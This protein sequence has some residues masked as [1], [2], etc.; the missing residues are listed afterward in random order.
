MNTVSVEACPR[1]QVVLP[2][3]ALLSLSFVVFALFLALLFTAIGGDA[4]LR[5]SDTFWHIGVGRGI[6]ETGSFPWVDHLSHTFEGHPWIARDW[7][8]EIIFALAYEGGGWPAVAG[9]TVGVIAL[10]FT[11]LFAELA[12]QMRL[13]AALSIAMLAYTLS[14][15]HFLARP[16]VLSYPVLVLWIAGLVRA[17]ESRTSPSLLLLPL[18]TLWANLH[19]SFTFGLAVGGL[20]AVEA[21]FES[22]PKQRLKTL[23]RW[24]IF[25]AAAAVAGLVT[26]YGYR[27]AFVTAQVFGGN[28]ALDYINEWRAM[29][30]SKEVLGG[31]LIIGLV[32]LGF[33]V[34]VKIRPMRLIIVTITFYM[35]L[36]HIR[37]VPIFA[38]ITPL[39]IASSL[40]VQF[41][42]LS[43]ESQAYAQPNL[44]DKL[45][46]V[47]KPR[48]ALILAV[49]IAGP[50]FL[51]FN[52]RRIG[53]SDSISPAAAVDFVLRTNPTGRL[54][55]DF[56]FGGYLIFRD[57]KT[58]IDGRT[59]QLFG[60]GFLAR[61]VKSSSNPNDGDFLKLL[62][63]YKVSSA[64][65]RPESGQASKLDRAPFW[66]RQYEDGMAAVY[67][68][69]RPSE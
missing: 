18:M 24:A 55:N 2:A 39:L 67:Q 20:L 7:L 56:S 25:L 49:L 52:A 1:A 23:S 59:D 62:D 41:P 43:V 31:P 66:R 30:F 13:T 45:L 3:R 63:E 69:V 8:S 64:L 19:G 15:I 51:T 38:L 58:F 9:V 46:R 17:V 34:G 36:V 60:G 5:D 14:S 4:L 42:F 22:C 33:L 28:E 10:T 21:I 35:M 61:M 37:M 53:P 57:V 68:R 54:Y 16:H 44:F 26:P 27:S 50:S 29:N 48:Y 65:V 11:L 12:R 40:I 32:F 6:L 47:S